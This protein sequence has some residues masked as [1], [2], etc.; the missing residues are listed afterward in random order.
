MLFICLVHNVLSARPAY[1][2]TYYISNAGSDLNDGLR[3]ATPWRTISRIDRSWQEISTGDDILFK[4]GDTF[5]DAVLGIQKGGTITDGLV[6]GAYG[7]G[8]KPV[9]DGQGTL[10]GA[11]SLTTPNISYVSIQDLDIRNTGLGQ[12]ILIAADNLAHITISRID[13]TGNPT[14]NGILLL[15]V[16]N[17]IIEDCSIKDVGNCGIFISGSRTFP[18]ANGIIRRNRVDCGGASND[19]ITIHQGGTS[20]GRPDVGPN[21][22][23]LS[24]EAF[25]CG[26]QG[27]D[28]TSGDNI[29][30]SGNETYNNGDGGILVSHM[31]SNVHIDE[32]YSHDDAQNMGAIIVGESTNVTMTRSVIRNA[33]YHAVVLRNC[34]TFLADNNTIV[35]GKDSRGSIIDIE[36]TADNIIFRNNTITSTGSNIGRYVR[37][38][39]GAT[40]ESTHSQFS[41][42][43]LWRPDKSSRLFYDDVLGD[44]DLS[45]FKKRYH[46][47]SDNLFKDPLIK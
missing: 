27:I 45:T 39:G 30:I 17:Y 11:I 44:Y 19:G 24:N 15:K 1:G 2:A 40:P 35:H 6:I 46:Q 26:E 14:R 9:L 32:H 28:I 29:L 37:Y 4:R 41:N 36:G 8:P 23:I 47:G 10:R 42:N 13:I 21:H 25:N 20:E 18:A 7:A 43:I 22:Q 3:K 38:L 33:R 5:S 31:A 16:N 12:S 34:G